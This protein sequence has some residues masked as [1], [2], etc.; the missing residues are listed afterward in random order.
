MDRTQSLSGT[1]EPTLA[2]HVLRYT[3]NLVRDEWVNIGVLLFDPRTAALRLRLIEDQD[4]FSRVRRL[5]PQADE[6]VI[7]QLRDHLEDRFATFL[8][9]EQRERQEPVLPGEA[10]QR[11]VDNW[12]ATLS[13]SIQL[14]PQKGVHAADLDQEL[15][16]LYAQHVASPRREIG[17]AASGSRAAMRAYCSQMWR[18]ARLWDKIE[19]SVRINEFTFPG[20]P[21]RIDYGYRRNDTRGFVQTLSVSGSPA[22]CK[23]FAYTA[24]RIAKRTPLAI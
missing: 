16:R 14:G 22:D 2:Y 13:N 24:D 5:Q 6:D 23:G 9:N 11:L 20:D 10:L 3:S 4:E 21:M 12:D 1:S 8:R 7:R 19:K 17:A 18:Q 15:E